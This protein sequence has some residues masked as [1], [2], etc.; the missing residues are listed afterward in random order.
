M[1]LNFPE[2]AVYA[3]MVPA[4]GLTSMIAFAQAILGF[5][6]VSE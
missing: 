4:L 5:T 3:V 1:L 2:W 6:E